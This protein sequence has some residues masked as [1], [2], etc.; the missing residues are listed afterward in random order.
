MGFSKALND[1]ATSHR[2][3]SKLEVI[4]DGMSKRDADDLRAALADTS[5]SN[6]VIARALTNEGHA[7]SESAVNG[8]RYKYLDA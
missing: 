2:K 7:I 3:R 5:L 6:A 4:L 8:H 1:A